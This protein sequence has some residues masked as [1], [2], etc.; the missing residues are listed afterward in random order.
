MLKLQR[1]T[2]TIGCVYCPPDLSTIIWQDLTEYLENTLPN[3]SGELVLVGDFKANLLSTTHNSHMTHL[4]RF[5]DNFCLCKQITTPKRTPSQAYLDL[6]LTPRVLPSHIRIA[7]ASVYSMPGLSDHHLVSS[8][9]TLPQGVQSTQFKPRKKRFPSLFKADFSSI[10]VDAI[11]NMQISDAQLRTIDDLTALWQ[12]SIL[13]SLNTFCPEVTT[14]AR[15]RPGAQPWSIP[16]LKSLHQA[17]IRLHRQSTQHPE[18]VT[19]RQE[20]QAARWQATI[21]NK[22]LRSCF[23]QQKFHSV[24]ASP[25]KR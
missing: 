3:N 9:L 11:S 17:R 1:H 6:V 21:L 5:L 20:F 10:A 16:E 19:L 15:R 14:N 24:Q 2:L 4:H 18:D 25:C 23:Y 7:H 22:S 12:Q 13:S 8:S